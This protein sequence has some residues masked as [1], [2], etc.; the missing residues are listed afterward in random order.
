MTTPTSLGYAIAIYEYDFDEKSTP[1]LSEITRGWLHH[2]TN[3][4]RFLAR[5]LRSS[6]KHDINRCKAAL[7][8]LL[9]GSTTVPPALALAS[10]ISRSVAPT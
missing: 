4:I 7:S 9:T 2:W 6:N 8:G 5:S 10:N 1:L 3:S